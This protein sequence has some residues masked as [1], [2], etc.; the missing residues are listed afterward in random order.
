MTT[1]PKC[2]GLLAQ[3]VDAYGPRLYCW[4]GCWQQD[5]TPGLPEYLVEI[6]EK[7]RGRGNKK[8]LWY[9]L[10]SKEIIGDGSASQAVARLGHLS[11]EDN[12]GVHTSLDN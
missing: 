10:H 9:G 1:C 6:N 2:G 7:P 11:V 12:P 5:L 4:N 8:S 3:E